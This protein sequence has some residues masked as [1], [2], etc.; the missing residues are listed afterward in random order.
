MDSM[1]SIDEKGMEVIRVF[2]EPPKNCFRHLGRGKYTSRFCFMCHCTHCT[3]LEERYIDHM[4]HFR[5]A[6]YNEKNRSTHRMLLDCYASVVG[7]MKAAE[8]YK[9]VN[10]ENHCSEFS[11]FE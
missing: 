5:D 3:S 4:R 6:I 7:K 2:R 10:C 8:M 11:R 9:C 1:D